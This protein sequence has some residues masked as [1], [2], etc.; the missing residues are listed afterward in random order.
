MHMVKGGG[1]LKNR[2]LEST[3]ERQDLKNKQNK[4][5]TH[6]PKDKIQTNRTSD[7]RKAK[8]LNF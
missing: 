2:N 7:V 4:T 5:N 3:E 6:T 8:K 1:K